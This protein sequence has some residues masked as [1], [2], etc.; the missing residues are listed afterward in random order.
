M[1]AMPLTYPGSSRP[2]PARLPGLSKLFQP[3]D[4]GVIDASIPTFFVGR[5]QDG[6]WLARDVKGETGGVFLF[7]ASAL[8][9]ARRASRPQPCATILLPD[10]FE[11]DIENEGNQFA[12]CL[13]PVARL[14]NLT[15][16]DTGR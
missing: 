15:G 7:K 13:K 1:T 9:F 11:L 12:F 4:P 6:F 5:N 10:R 2:Q 8:A 3:L 14:L 16:K